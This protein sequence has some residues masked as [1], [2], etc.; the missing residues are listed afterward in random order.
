MST[1]ETHSPLKTTEP[2]GVE[3][4]SERIKELDGALDRLY[5]EIEANQHEYADLSHRLR[6]TEAER[7]RHYFKL[8]TMADM[9]EDDQ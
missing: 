3:E 1:Y 6:V 7:Y 2:I 9:E 8:L 5:E 4:T